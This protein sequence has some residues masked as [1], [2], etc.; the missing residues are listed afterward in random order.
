MLKKPLDFSFLE[1]SKKNISNI[2]NHLRKLDSYL[3]STGCDDKL[4]YSELSKV[5]IEGD[6]LN[7]NLRNNFELNILSDEKELNKIDLNTVNP[8]KALMSFNDG[9]VTI[10]INMLPPKRI[11]G[12]NGSRYEG[13]S[14]NYY[15]NAL[16][17]AYSELKMTYTYKD[18]CVLIYK[19]HFNKKERL[20]DLDN[21]D[22]KKITDWLKVHFLNDDS[23][24]YLS[25]VFDGDYTD[26]ESSLDIIMKPYDTV[27]GVI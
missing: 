23:F 10:H 18:K 19:V 12:L 5:F 26:E 2:E 20:S 13:D 8:I 25:Q 16:E 11:K 15:T 14:F 9:I 21:Y 1:S 3:D 4:A 6:L 17:K 27:K 22:F 24:I 7:R